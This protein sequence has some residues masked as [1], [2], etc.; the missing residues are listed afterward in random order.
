M[1][2]DLLFDSCLEQCRLA[3]STGRHAKLH[4]EVCRRLCDNFESEPG[5]ELLGPVHFEH[6]EPNGTSVFL[7]LVANLKD[8]MSSDPTAL[9][10]RDNPNA[11]E[12]DGIKLREHKKAPNWMS[13]ENNNLMPGDCSLCETLFLLV[14]VPPT[15][16]R[17][18]MRTHRLT[19][20]FSK[21]GLVFF[22][23]LTK[24][25]VRTPTFIVPVTI[26]QRDNM[27]H[28]VL[29]SQPCPANK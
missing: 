19:M 20:K 10:G 28:T 24:R 5:V 9:C 14:G 26:R 7:C 21:E 6:L 4:D 17:L 3:S 18:N 2:A 29:S 16:C 27:V 25:N 15:Q 11:A 22:G 8:E 23:C 12:N 1:L 13:V